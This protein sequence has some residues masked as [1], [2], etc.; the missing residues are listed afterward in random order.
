MYLFLLMYILK[1]SVRR[2]VGISWIGIEVGKRLFT[3][4]LHIRDD[5]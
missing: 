3:V 2:R 4:Y 5:F 1:L